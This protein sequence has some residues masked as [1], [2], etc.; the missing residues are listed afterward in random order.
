MVQSRRKSC[1]AFGYHWPDEIGKNGVSCFVQLFTLLLLLGQ[2]GCDGKPSK[3]NDSSVAETKPSQLQKMGTGRDE[4]KALEDD[5]TEPPQAP[6]TIDAR[7][8]SVDDLASRNPRPQETD[9][10]RKLAISKDFDWRE[11]GRVMD[12]WEKLLARSDDCFSELVAHMDDDRYSITYSRLSSFET[13]SVGD[14]CLSIV[15]QRLEQFFDDYDPRILAFQWVRP[16]RSERRSWSVAHAGM[17][18]AELQ[19]EGLREMEK[20]FA[21]NPEYNSVKDHYLKKIET[22]RRTIRSTKKPIPYQGA[23]FHT[24]D[25]FDAIEFLSK[26]KVIIKDD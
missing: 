3:K 19:L 14:I 4:K 2:I 20:D 6:E 8:V 1:V 12:V 16:N 9:S 17:S 22:L 5:M 13:C 18:L 24:H 25:E 21:S 11:E 10:R 15:S 7:N 23:A 26:R